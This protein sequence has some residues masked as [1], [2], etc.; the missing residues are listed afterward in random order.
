[1]R[2]KLKSCVILAIALGAP[3]QAQNQLFKVTASDGSAGDRYGSVAASG[4][5]AVVGAYRHDG[6]GTDSG[7]AYVLDLVTGQE[8]YMLA[9]ADA[10]AGQNFGL[11]VAI[12]GKLAVIGAHN[13]DE[14]GGFAAG[15]A[16]VFDLETGAQLHKLMAADGAATDQFGVDVAISGTRV[17]IGAHE[18]DE[19]G[20]NAGA[21]YVFDALTGQEL[22]KL[23]ASDSASGDI[24]GRCVAI[25][26]DL[27][28]VGAYLNDD[29]GSASGAA[30]VF[31]V[32]TGQELH[33]LTASDAESDDAF[34]VSVA[35]VADKALVGAHGAGP[36]DRGTA[37][38]FD[39]TSGQEM[40]ILTAPDGQ[41]GD[42]FGS[43]APLVEAFGD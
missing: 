26:G 43:P 23:T 14:N 15:A 32:S 21:A 13:D 10:K 11:S 4:N 2:P 34:G 19:A 5:L 29:A 20:V 22:F 6:A 39:A 38:L 41:D 9:P 12:S 33:K 8:L 30:Y 40:A 42:F 3:A 16:Y 37:Y 17:I 1:M 24:F 25:W 27:A 36:G 18:D 35:L 31:D 7:T 28:I